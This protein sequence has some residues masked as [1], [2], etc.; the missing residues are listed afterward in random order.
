MCVVLTHTGSRRLSQAPISSA[1]GFIV[2]SQTLRKTMPALLT[3]AARAKAKAKARKN[4]HARKRNKFINFECWILNVESSSRS[5][6]NILNSKLSE[7]MRL[8]LS[9]IAIMWLFPAVAMR[10]SVDA[11]CRAPIDVVNYLPEYSRL[12][13]V[14]YFDS[15]SSVASDSYLGNKIHITA[16]DSMSLSYAVD[17]S[18]RV[19]IALLPTASD[20]LT[21][22]IKELPAPVYDSTV[23]FYDNRWHRLAPFQ[24]KPPS[25]SDWLK[26]KKRAEAVAF[27]IPFVLATADCRSRDHA[28]CL[29][30]PHRPL[31]L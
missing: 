10:P 22:V 5:K 15:G 21:M 7:M 25:F 11:F 3:D 19:T 30:Q 20:T 17:D 29:H 8:I 18:V 27:D 12:D 23:S 6:F 13:M 31:F 9:F 24:L 16:L 4:S 1:S 2:K 28:S 26:D 14:D